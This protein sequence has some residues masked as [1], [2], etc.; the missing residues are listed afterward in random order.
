MRSKRD[1]HQPMLGAAQLPERALH[2][3]LAG[4]RARD[5]LRQDRDRHRRDEL[6]GALRDAVDVARD[7]G[8]HRGR[9]RGDL[10]RSILIDV[11]D[12]DDAR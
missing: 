2:V 5:V 1:A 10:N 3:A 8:A 6:V 12:V 4:D 9:G 11:V 7:L